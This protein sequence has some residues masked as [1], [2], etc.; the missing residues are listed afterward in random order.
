MG[1]RPSFSPSSSTCRRM[2]SW[3]SPLSHSF[4]S[5]SHSSPAISLLTARPASIPSSRFVPS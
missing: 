1:R 4:W 3:L 5:R 2:T